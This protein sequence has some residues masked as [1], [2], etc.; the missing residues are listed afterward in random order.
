MLWRVNHWINERWPLTI[1]L[2]WGA[3]SDD[4]CSIMPTDS[5]GGAA[6]FTAAF[7]DGSETVAS[8]IANE[9]AESADNE[10]RLMWRAANRLFPD[11]YADSYGLGV[12]LF[13]GS[14]GV[15]IGGGLSF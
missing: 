12:G 14:G 5:G 3:R 11:D 9:R 7:C 13:G 8:V 10:K 2:R 6:P 4:I 1:V 15:G